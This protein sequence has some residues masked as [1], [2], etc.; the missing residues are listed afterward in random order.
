MN[1]QKHYNA[2]IAN[3]KARTGLAIKERHHIKPCSTCRFSKRYGERSDFV[4]NEDADVPSNIVELT[5]REH[6]I[7]HLLL[8]KS[9]G[10][11]VWRT[12]DAFAAASRGQE[13]CTGAMYEKARIRSASAISD[14]MR[15]IREDRK[16]NWHLSDEL[17]QEHFRK[18]SEA[19]KGRKRPQSFVDRIKVT[20]SE[21]DVSDSTK[22]KISQK[23]SGFSGVYVTPKGE[24]STLMSA[25][26][27]NNCAPITVKRRCLNPNQLNWFKLEPNCL[28]EE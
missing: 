4:W 14:K 17:R 9:Y 23:L 2:L 16:G 28:D 3:A 8:A 21:R 18:I 22:K 11:A 24:F 20:N 12:V 25:G 26:R 27:A 19:H 10:D 1:Y 7:A 13:R 6:Y 5:P 15:K